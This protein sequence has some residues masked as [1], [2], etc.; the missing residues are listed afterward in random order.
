[1]RQEHYMPRTGR[2]YSVNILALLFWIPVR[3]MQNCGF[4]LILIKASEEQ[5]TT[6]RIMWTKYHWH[7]ASMMIMCKR[8]EKTSKS[9]TKQKHSPFLEDSFPVPVWRNAFWE[10]VDFANIVFQI[11][12]G[13]KHI[14]ICL[15]TWNYI[16]NINK[17]DIFKIFNH[18]I[19]RYF[20]R[21]KGQGRQ[22]GSLQKTCCG[23]GFKIVCFFFLQSPN[24]NTCCSTKEKYILW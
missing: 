1:M 3:H 11:V 13:Q 5:A 2:Q 18:L 21:I 15:M 8:R 24:T 6:R 17:F 23:Y 14:I 9:K 12:F 10:Q 22:D 20:W 4:T 16:M 7:D 19:M